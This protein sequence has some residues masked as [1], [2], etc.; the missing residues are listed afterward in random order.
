MLEQ[1]RIS[2]CQVG[3]QLV[4]RRQVGLTSIRSLSL[5]LS[6][7]VWDKWGVWKDIHDACVRIGACAW[8]PTTV[9]MS[10]G[11]VMRLFIR[12][13]YSKRVKKKGKNGRLER[14]GGETLLKT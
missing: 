10:G 12:Y 8:S 2:Q 6:V 5:S 14:G 1:T 3:C 9:E 7:C 4:D 11:R 13:Y